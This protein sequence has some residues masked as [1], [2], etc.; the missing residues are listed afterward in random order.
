MKEAVG[1]CAIITRWNFPKLDGK[2]AVIT[3]GASGIHRDRGQDGAHRT[4]RR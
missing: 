4:R 1:V 3:G 2:T